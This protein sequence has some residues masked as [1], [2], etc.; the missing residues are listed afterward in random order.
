MCGKE[1]EMVK[2]YW[3]GA[4]KENSKTRLLFLRNGAPEIA[5]S[6]AAWLTR[7]LT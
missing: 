3:I 7:W 6:L 5:L 2:P 1:R 4:N